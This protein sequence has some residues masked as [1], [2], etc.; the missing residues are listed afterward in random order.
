MSFKWSGVAQAAPLQ[1]LTGYAHNS[2][3]EYSGA[4]LQEVRKLLAKMNLVG[5]PFGDFPAAQLHWIIADASGAITL[6]CTKD[7]SGWRTAEPGE[8]GMNRELPQRLHSVITS[9]YAN[10]NGIVVV[11]NGCIV[12]E[13]YFHGF[14]YLSGN[15]RSE[16]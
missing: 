14:G 8:Q 10:T 4:N 16:K 15:C 12:C 2:K 11:R 5:T 7:V 9:D 13:E 3:S 6:E 1:F